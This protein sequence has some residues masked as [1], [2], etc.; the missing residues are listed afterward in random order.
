MHPG[1]TDMNDMPRC[2]MTASRACVLAAMSG[3]STIGAWQTSTWIDGRVGHAASSK[4]RTLVIVMSRGNHV[5]WKSSKQSPRGS[6]T[7]R[8][9]GDGRRRDVGTAA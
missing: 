3:R 6:Q 1:V 8:R 2:A 4:Y 7:R 5:N 9:R